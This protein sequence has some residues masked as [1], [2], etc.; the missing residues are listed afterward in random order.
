MNLEI[1]KKILIPIKMSCFLKLFIIILVV[2]FFLLV[3]IVLHV[4]NIAIST[5]VYRQASPALFTALSFRIILHLSFIF[6]LIIEGAHFSFRNLNLRFV[7]LFK[8]YF[9]SSALFSSDLRLSE[10]LGGVLLLLES[11]LLL[12]LFF[13]ELLLANWKGVVWTRCLSGIFVTIEY[14]GFPV[15]RITRICAVIHVVFRIAAIEMGREHRIIQ[16]VAGA[17]FDV[18]AHSGELILVELSSLLHHFHSFQKLQFLLFSLP[19][20]SESGVQ[21]FGF[22]A[23]KVFASLLVKFNFLQNLSLLMSICSG[24]SIDILQTVFSLDHFHLFFDEGF[25]L[26]SLIFLLLLNFFLLSIRDEEICFFLTFHIHDFSDPFLILFALHILLLLY[27]DLSFLFLRENWLSFICFGHWWKHLFL[28]HK[29]DVLRVLKYLLHLF[30]FFFG[31]LFELI[32]FWITL[33]FKFVSLCFGSHLSS[34]EK[35]SLFLDGLVGL[36]FSL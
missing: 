33:A 5:R 15:R 4:L 7:F 17:R 26:S 35:F 23:L 1:N 2:V 11:D 36:L 28:L 25:V 21:H 22:L 24:N 16:P 14:F 34:L 10:L 19:S 29:L 32:M 18:D 13:H 8:I 3:K 12:F 31:L 30:W 6:M 20:N 9:E 27:L